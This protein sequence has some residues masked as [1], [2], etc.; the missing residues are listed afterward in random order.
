[1]NNKKLII[2]NSLF[3]TPYECFELIHDIAVDYDG[4]RGV[5]VLMS[6]IDEI[7]EYSIAGMKMCKTKAR[8]DNND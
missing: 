1:M 6:L 8:N 3:T 4:Y 7:K 2:N 5:K